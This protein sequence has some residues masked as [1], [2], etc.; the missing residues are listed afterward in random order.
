[1]DLGSTRYS[2]CKSRMTL[3]VA[4]KRFVN[5]SSSSD[6]VENKSAGV[7]KVNSIKRLN[8]QNELECSI[9]KYLVFESFSPHADIFSVDDPL[10]L[11]HH[12]KE[13]L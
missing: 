2:A 4:V 5:P 10:N 11:P 1:M 7:D 9:A 12:F 3:A 13:N 8:D 6:A